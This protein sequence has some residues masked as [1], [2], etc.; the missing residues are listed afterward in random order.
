MIMKKCYLTLLLLALT[1]IGCTSYEDRLAKCDYVGE[2]C[3]GF[4]LCEEGESVYFINEKGRKVSKN[5]NGAEPF[6]NGYA[7]VYSADKKIVIDTQFNEY[8]LNEENTK[9]SELVNPNGTIWA[10]T[11]FRNGTGSFACP[12]NLKTMGA[13]M[14]L[15]VDGIDCVT[16]DGYAVLRRENNNFPKRKGASTVYEYAIYDAE[17]TEIVPFG[18]YTFIGDFHSGLA[19]FSTTGY[20]PM[21]STTGYDKTKHT[22]LKNM[23][24]ITKDITSIYFP[25]N[26]N[27]SREGTSIGY[28]NVK[29]EIVIPEQY[30]SAKDFND[31]GYAE[32]WLDGKPHYIDVKNNVQEGRGIAVA[33]ASYRSKSEWKF[34]VDED[35]SV[36]IVDH[37]GNIYLEGS[38]RFLT[39]GEL[40][41]AQKGSKY[42]FHLYDQNTGHA[43]FRFDIANVHPGAVFYSMYDEEKDIVKIA[44]C[45]PNESLYI[46]DL[47]GNLL[48]EDYYTRKTEYPQQNNVIETY[49]DLFQP[50]LMFN[51]FQAQ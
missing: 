32:I 14:M 15:Q 33:K 43:N 26:I 27:A 42:S 46:Y 40:L 44:I 7:F 19:R 24:A 22:S 34:Y 1:T 30:I 29:G 51:A 28:I 12:L 2:F 49:S 31:R 9:Y 25:M 3:D 48:L 8:V 36:F 50:V 20:A 38:N 23:Q 11:N 16:D 47:D 17:G 39:C 13:D 4:A 18:K 10:L 37:D 41:I 35:N 5:Y 45:N 21:S 6:K